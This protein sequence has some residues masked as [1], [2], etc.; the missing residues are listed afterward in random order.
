MQQFFFL[1]AVCAGW[2]VSWKWKGRHLWLWVEDQNSLL[3]SKC[4][5]RDRWRMETVRVWEQTTGLWGN[6]RSTAESMWL[7]L[8]SVAPLGWTFL[9]AEHPGSTAKAATLKHRENLACPHGTH[10][11]LSHGSGYIW[12]R[13][14]RRSRVSQ[15]LLSH[16]S[17]SHTSHQWSSEVEGVQPRTHTW[18]TLILITL[19][20]SLSLMKPNS[21]SVPP[22][23]TRL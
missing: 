11:G 13:A 23:R 1:F 22:S 9:C 10:I 17:P 20:Q 18:Q 2:A 5:D 21:H 8:F 19:K 7:H 3:T 15:I 16:D 4:S 12:I 14:P 6:L